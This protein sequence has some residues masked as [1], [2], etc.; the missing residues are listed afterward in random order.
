[1]HCHSIIIFLWS[2]CPWNLFFCICLTSFFS[3]LIHC[4]FTYYLLGVVHLNSLKNSLPFQIRIVRIALLWNSPFLVFDSYSHS[5]EDSDSS[6]GQLRLSMLSILKTEYH[7]KVY[8]HCLCLLV[9]L[10]LGKDCFSVFWDNY[11]FLFPWNSISTNKKLYSL[12]SCIIIRQ[13]DYF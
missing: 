5:T 13:V 4:S 11:V 6:H 2:S 8:C 9:K 3:F 10:L 1:M 7:I 12:P